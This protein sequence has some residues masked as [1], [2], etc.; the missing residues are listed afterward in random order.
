MNKFIVMIFISLGVGAAGA[1]AAGAGAGAGAG[2]GVRDAMLDDLANI[3]ILDGLDD[4]VDM[5]VH[6]ETDWGEIIMKI[7]VGAYV[8]FYQDDRDFASFLASIATIIA[9]VFSIA[10]IVGAIDCNLKRS[11]LG[12]VGGYTVG[13]YCINIW[14]K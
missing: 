11:D 6:D 4:M 1:G 10:W 5:Y 2:G 3:I 12:Y 9:V 7:I 8:G 13:R 14:C